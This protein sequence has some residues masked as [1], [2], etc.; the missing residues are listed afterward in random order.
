MAFLDPYATLG[1][2]ITA[3]QLRQ[4]YYESVKGFTGI[5]DADALRVQAV[6]GSPGVAGIGPGVGSISVGSRRE[7][8]QVSNTAMDGDALVAVPTAG[9]SGATLYVIVE[10]TDPEYHGQEPATTPRVVSS[11]AGLSQPYLLLARIELE[12]GETFGVTSVVEDLREVTHPATHLSAWSV[13]PTSVV[14]TPQSGNWE[15]WVRFAGARVIP[16]WAGRVQLVMLGQGLVVRD[17]LWHGLA[18][19]FFRTSAGTVGTEP[20][21]LRQDA[22][23]ADDRF[24][25]VLGD[26]MTIHSSRAG[27]PAD[28]WLQVQRLEGAGQLEVNSGS[29]LHLAATWIQAAR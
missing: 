4:M 1:A 9:S 14:R 26:L 6:P 10:V 3:A 13:R 24:T 29:T 12:P 2:T 17:A 19:I 25:L 20:V 7:A 21:S 5:S 23:D 18:R 27:E 8:Y 16:E 22:T 11:L 28:I 15:D